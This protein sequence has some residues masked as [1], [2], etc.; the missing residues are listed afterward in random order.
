MYIYKMK[1][2]ILV[3]YL[4]LFVFSQKTTEASRL[5]FIKT[6]NHETFM[7]TG[8]NDKFYYNCSNACEDITIN[9]SEDYLK[10]MFYGVSKKSKEKIID[11]FFYQY[12]YLLFYN[13]FKS[14]TI[15][16]EGMEPITRSLELARTEN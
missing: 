7:I 12:N 9:I 3:L 13:G 15:K 16:L 10:Q 2:L 4:P 5:E 8:D 11:T 6:A 1:L 14:L